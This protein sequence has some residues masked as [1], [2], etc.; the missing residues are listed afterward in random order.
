MRETSERPSDTTDTR[1]NGGE[2]EV[3]VADTFKQD[4]TSDPAPNVSENPNRAN[5][6]IKLGHRAR[7]PARAG[8]LVLS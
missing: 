4:D 7:K 3:D 5:A 6:E 1:N 8:I 2:D